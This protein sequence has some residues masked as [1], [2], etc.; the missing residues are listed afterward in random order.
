MPANGDVAMLL[1]TG[2][3]AALGILGTW[4]IETRRRR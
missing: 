1:L 3:I 2:S 4:H